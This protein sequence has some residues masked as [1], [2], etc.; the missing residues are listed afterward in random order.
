MLKEYDVV[1]LTQVP[2]SIPLK[3]GAEGTVL[4][5]HESEPRKYEVEFMGRDGKSLGTFTVDEENLQ[6]LMRP[7]A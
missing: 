7:E 4:L 6:L 5:V 1:R 2:A 3:K